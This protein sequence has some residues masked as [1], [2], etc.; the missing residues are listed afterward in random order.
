MF[1]SMIDVNCVS[2][3]KHVQ[4]YFHVKQSREFSFDVSF[5]F[6]SGKTT[7]Q[8]N[9]INA[10]IFLSNFLLFLLLFKDFVFSYLERF[11]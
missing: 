4:G 9:N 6:K 2:L 11:C 8:P 5:F 3:I 10:L 1:I 7:K